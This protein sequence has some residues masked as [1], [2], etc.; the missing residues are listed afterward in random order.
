MP[1]LFPFLLSHNLGHHVHGGFGHVVVNHRFYR[2]CPKHGGD[3]NDVAVSLLQVGNGL[4]GHFVWSIQIGLQAN[5][6]KL[7]QS[8]IDLLT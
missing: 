3:E 1:L 5:A 2:L 4:L 6:D 8:Q 7:S